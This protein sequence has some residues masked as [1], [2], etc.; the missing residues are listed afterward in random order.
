MSR[1][2]VGNWAMTPG[3]RLEVLG[4]RARPDVEHRHFALA[5]NVILPLVRVGM[6]M[7]L[8]QAARMHDHE[9][10]RNGERRLEIAAVSDAYFATRG[11]A[12]GWHAVER[13]R[14]RIGYLADGTLGLRLVLRQRSG[15]L[16]RADI[17]LV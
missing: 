16:A 1:L 3:A 15:H 2:F 17:E 5:G 11:L 7:H 6:P 8:T 14:R 10:G 12:G 9:R 4:H 13:E